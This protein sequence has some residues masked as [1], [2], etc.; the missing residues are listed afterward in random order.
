MINRAYKL[1]S[2]WKSFIGECESL[3]QMFVNLPYPLKLID[4]T[5]NKFISSHITN[6]ID[7]TDE[8]SNSLPKVLVPLPFID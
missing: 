1:S 3:K 2:T 5:I 4:T 7:T 6:E 8:R